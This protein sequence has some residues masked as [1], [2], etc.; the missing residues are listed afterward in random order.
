M[1]IAGRILAAWV[2]FGAIA[3]AIAADKTADEI[4]KEIQGL[5]PPQFVQKPGEDQQK[6][7]EAYFADM[8]KVSEKRV[9]L[10]GDL[11]KADPEN[12]EL[13]KLLP[14]R[15]SL[16]AQTGKTDE[17]MAEIDETLAKTKSETLKAEGHYSK[18]QVLMM[19][20]RG[21]ISAAMP[22]IEEFLKVAPKG[23]RR[24]PLFLYNVLRGTQDE[25]KK[26][27]IEERILKDY[28]DSQFA[29]MIK[30][31]RKQRESIG[32][33]FELEFTEAT[34]GTTISMKDLK[35]KVVV[36]DFWATWCGPCIKEMP[37]MKKLYAEYKDKGV[38]FIGVSLDKKKEDGG[39]DKLKDY[40][41]KND[42]QWPQYYQ[43][44][45]WESEF[46][47]GW[48]INSIPCVFIVDADGKLYSVEAGGKLETL[49]PELL[50]KAKTAPG[51]GGQ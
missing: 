20:N 48:G 39:L 7:R 41:A 6:L 4:L 19:K 3:P 30:G 32:K 15:W 16:L 18:A 13:V 25:A 9:E 36:V 28:G 49:I 1:R 10:I 5:K 21:N 22:A 2:V 50:K 26:T 24:A 29:G 34:R 12:K 45:W 27:A 37:T 46:S 8:K 51:A 47:A 44:N 43:G 14:Q 23:D 42:I 17:A 11:R 40:V 31:A 38:E 33:P 35:G